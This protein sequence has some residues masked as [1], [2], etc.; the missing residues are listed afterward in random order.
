MQRNRPV[1]QAFVYSLNF[2]GTK[3]LKPNQMCGFGRTT[4]T[5]KQ[6]PLPLVIHPGVIIT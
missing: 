4:A 6:S 5:S 2:V 3:T 1:Q